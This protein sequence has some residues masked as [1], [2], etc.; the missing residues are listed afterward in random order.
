MPPA[1]GTLA[2]RQAV[3]QENGKGHKG[4]LGKTG[5]TSYSGP[6]VRSTEHALRYIVYVVLKSMEHVLLYI[7]HFP[8]TTEHVLWMIQHVLRTLEHVLQTIEHVV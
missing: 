2:A 4:N 6:T 3:D 8:W 5:L 7:D 1:K